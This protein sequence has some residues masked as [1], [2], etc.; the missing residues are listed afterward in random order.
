MS[1]RR[2]LAFSLG[3]NAG[4]FV[5]QFATSIV[6]ARLLTPAEF[7]VYAAATAVTN[8]INSVLNVGLGGWLVRERELGADKIGS[9]FA[10]ALIQAAVLALGLLALSWP[11]G[12]FT[13]DARVTQSLHVLVLFAA[14]TPIIAALSGLLQRRMQFGLVTAIGLTNVAV[15]AAATIA[16][17]YGGARH[18]A[19]PWGTGIGSAAALLLAL[20][21]QR[22]DLRVRLNLVHA[23]T[24]WRYGIKI[25]SAAFIVNVTG[26]LPDIL[27]ARLAG[28]AATGLYN[29][30]AGLVDTFTNTIMRSFQRVMQSQFARD[31][32]TAAGIGPGYAQMSRVLTGL[33]WPAFAVLAALASPIIDLL[34]G[35]QWHAAAP[36][37]S[38]LALASIV[39]LMVSCRQQ[40]LI[41]VGREADL[42]R[43]ELVRGVVGVIL[44]AV[45]AYWGLVWAAA[46]RLVDAALSVA[47]YAPGIHAATRLTWGAMVRAFARSAVLAVL[48]A[49]P[50]VV[51]MAWRGWPDTLP[52][53]ELLATLGAC[54]A[55]WL[56]SIFALGHAL[57]HE[58]ARFLRPLWRRL[59]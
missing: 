10:L 21:I 12:W 3:G 34:Y 50:A 11:I 52:V 14:T 54:G 32:D 15:S 40:V 18:L 26:R 8:I 29:R 44:F 20:A 19:M 37:L 45:G 55:L 57:G 43:I 23:R 22:R 36:V 39:A 24:I 49:A 16:L 46:S 47:L 56:A 31:R 25:V 41:T 6:L 2:S 7:G 35:P 13:G 1:V 17:A 33:F 58:V 38:I 9:A 27:L 28:L 30:G 42:P 5:I 48:T 51:W 4:F 59:R 53:A